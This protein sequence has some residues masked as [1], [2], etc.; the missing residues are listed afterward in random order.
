MS[1]LPLSFYQLF[2]LI[3]CLFQKMAQYLYFFNINNSY[4]K[5]QENI[6]DCFRSRCF[7][8]DRSV[9]CRQQQLG[10]KQ[11]GAAGYGDVVGKVG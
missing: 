2:L 3:L 10:A 8:A 6:I 9:F 11:T 1:K 4:Q 5:H 7:A